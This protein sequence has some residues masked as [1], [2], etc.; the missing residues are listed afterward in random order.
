MCAP[1]L[2]LAVFPQAL[3]QVIGGVHSRGAARRVAAK[4]RR[5]FPPVA[6][7]TNHVG[8]LLAVW[9]GC[10][11]LAVAAPPAA[12]PDAYDALWGRST[13]VAVPGVLANDSD[14][15]GDPLTAVLVSGPAH[16]ELVFPGDGSFVY[17]ANGVYLGEDTFTYKAHDGTEHSGVVT[18]TVTVTNH[19]PVAADDA[20]E[21]LWN[22]VLYVGAP[23]LPEVLANDSDADGDQLVAVKVTDPAHGTVIFH[24]DGRFDY[25]PDEDYVGTDTFTYKAN[26]AVADSNVA[27]VAIKVR[28]RDWFA[29]GEG[30]GS[31]VSALTCGAPGDL[32]VGG[33]FTTAG[34][35]AANR[36]ARWDG[37]NWHALGLGVGNEVRA[38]A[39]DGTGTLY[40]G[41][42]FNSAGG[43]AA[44]HVAKWDGTSWHALGAGVNGD[45]R[46]LAL[47]ASGALYV[48][49]SFTSAG[50]VAANG[51]ARWD[52][53]AWSVLGAGVND[54]VKALAVGASG[55]LYV[56]GSFSSAGGVATSSIAKWNGTSW[57]GLGTGM[58]GGGVSGL[59]LD[60]SGILYACGEFVTAG[61]A[62][63]L[64]I[65]RWNGTAWSA[66]CPP[67]SELPGRNFH[68][69]ASDA[70]GNVYAGGSFPD[71]LIRNAARWDGTRWL[72]LGSGLG[73]DVQALA[74]DAA[75][76][77]FAG[78]QFTTAGGN[79]ANHVA[80][81][82]VPTPP[83]AVADS[84]GA[85][86]DT[87]LDVAAPG[88]LANDSGAGGEV[89]T[90]AKVTDPAHGTLALNANGSF[91]YTPDAGYA[92]P[93]SFTYKANDGVD[94]S[95]VA[96]VTITVWD[97]SW[98]A[99][100]A[101]IDGTVYALAHDALGNLYAGGDFSS[102]RRAA[103]NHIAKW[104]GTTWSAL[105]DGMDGP[106]FS[107]ALDGTGTLYAAG[108]FTLAGGVA[109][110]HV[111]KWDGTAWSALGT[112]T[113]GH[114]N[115]LAYDGAGNLYVG[116]DFTT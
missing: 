12:T 1:R 28:A 52:G 108:D 63:A 100:G 68:A 110:N 82:D 30:V 11:I 85:N 73:D 48:G 72:L 115:A 69:L 27:T 94:D 54:E 88:V 81:Y 50:G 66:L 64:H 6:G 39:W 93:D 77:L 47:D 78:G 104:D 87:A 29:L 40:V 65:A 33:S 32:Y 59:A 5:Q 113:D 67:A 83:V 91:T 97:G 18:V 102:V 107:L 74:V 14:P 103:A 109:V 35:G 42:S 2:C 36:I 71:G 38:L 26:D 105:G 96:T 7:I 23:G 25:T 99:L 60:A 57:V 43:V 112:G 19:A 49:G 9:L 45:V 24:G 114:V 21:A 16:G 3:L 61:G 79:A 51:V 34:G 101:E 58:A 86:W 17:T 4:A 106:V 22:A 31:P 89:L 53:A 41:G 13:P 80:R 70:V 10:G 98:D 20:Y 44:N 37:S 92:G 84:Y 62:D 56:G 8:W 55:E 75:G 116:G 95:S 15:D 111:A 90:A 76:G 46:A